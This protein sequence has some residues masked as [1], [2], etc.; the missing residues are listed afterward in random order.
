MN[1]GA[2]SF[3]VTEGASIHP[4]SSSVCAAAEHDGVAS[5]SGTAFDSRHLPSYSFF[6][7]LYYNQFLIVIDAICQQEEFSLSV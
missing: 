1:C 5:A 3:A 6:F 7:F 4:S 2:A